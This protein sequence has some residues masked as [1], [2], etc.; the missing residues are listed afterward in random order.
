MANFTGSYILDKSE[1]FEEYLI[2][3][4]I[5]AEKAKA[6]A[7]AATQMDIEHSGDQMKIRV[8]A[9][10]TEISNLTHTIGKQLDVPRPDGQVMKT[11]LTLDGKKAVMEQIDGKGVKEVIVRDLQA[12]GSIVATMTSNGVTA[13]RRFKKK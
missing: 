1:G 3:R 12:D 2:A 11:T 7:A 10:D 5:S 13:T 4:G 6:G 8:C 9:G